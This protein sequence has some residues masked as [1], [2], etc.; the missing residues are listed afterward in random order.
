[1]P[2]DG[3]TSVGCRGSAVYRASGTYPSRVP[4]AS[5]GTYPSVMQKARLILVC[6]LPGSGKTTL[7]KQLATA[8]RAVRLS[9]M[10]GST[11]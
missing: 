7:A 5:S 4:R 3:P 6:G 11:P 8:V 1:M 2:A 9:L 10:S